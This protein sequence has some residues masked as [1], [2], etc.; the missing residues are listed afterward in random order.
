MPLIDSGVVRQYRFDNSRI[1]MSLF[2][3][4]LLGLY[5]KNVRKQKFCL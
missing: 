4:K 5:V 2:N 3:C 1:L